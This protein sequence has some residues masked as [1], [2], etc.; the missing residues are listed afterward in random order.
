MYHRRSLRIESLRIENLQYTILVYHTRIESLRIEN[1]QHTRPENMKIKRGP[2]VPALE[3]TDIEETEVQKDIIPEETT[4]MKEEIIEENM[5]PVLIEEIIVQQGGT[6]VM[7]GMIEEI[8]V[9]GADRT[10]GL[11]IGEITLQMKAEDTLDTI[12]EGDAKGPLVM[13]G[14]L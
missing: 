8:R 14:P 10:L 11:D 3:V 6:T 1:L 5:A 7:T 4:M 13:E 2:E 12:G 9:P